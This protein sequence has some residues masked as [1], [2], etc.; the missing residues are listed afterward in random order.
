[1]ALTEVGLLWHGKRASPVV[2]FCLG[3]VRSNHHRQQEMGQELCAIGTLTT[4]RCDFGSTDFQNGGQRQQRLVLP[5]L[6]D[7]QY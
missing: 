6:P 4:Q 2:L 3:P 5:L 7:R 1:M